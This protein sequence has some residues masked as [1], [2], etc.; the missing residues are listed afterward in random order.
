MIRMKERNE[1]LANQLITSS[2]D[3]MF[4]GVVAGDNPGE[5]WVDD[6][7]NPSSALVWSSG[8]G[9]FTFM[10]DA[11]N[12]AFN[13]S[14]EKLIEDEVIPFLKH[15]DVSYFEFSV[16]SEDWY[17]ALY[18]YIG[19]RKI[20][21][22][23]QYV[24]KSTMEPVQA[25]SSDAIGDFK[26]VEINE[27]LLLELDKRELK[28]ADFLVNYIE[29]YW[30]TISNYIEN[31]YGYAALSEMNEVASIAVSSAKFQSTQSIGVE[32]LEN[33]Q[34]QGLSGSLVTLLLQKFNECQII[35]W[36]D[37]MESNIASQKTAEKAGLSRSH[38]YQ[39]N[40]FHF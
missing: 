17:P 8:L 7:L 5:V 31:G 32:T 4:A 26:V 33:Y 25:S 3:M 21:K 27:T 19:N 28:N 35:A 23:Y 30:G 22:S 20:D 38:R 14:I 15:K 13:Q 1:W 12:H 34:R 29:Q 11:R 36:W 2:S 24:Y 10:G 9:C 16:D 37:C 40:W 6:E 18:E 39:I